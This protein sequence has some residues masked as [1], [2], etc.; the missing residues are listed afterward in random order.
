M[1]R[2]LGFVLGGMSGAAGALAVL[3]YKTYQQQLI[4]TRR[5]L[6]AGAQIIETSKGNGE[7]ASYGDGPPVLVLHGAGGGYN[8][9][10]S[11]I[12]T[13]EPNFRW[14]SVSRFGYLGTPLPSDA[15]PAAQA[16]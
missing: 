3:T 1:R 15:S 13:M 9:S 5:K 10:L 14:L 2:K 11:L 7:Y 4:G 6:S 12:R 8:Q 16:G